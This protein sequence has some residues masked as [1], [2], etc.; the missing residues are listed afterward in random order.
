M[1]LAVVN[2]GSVPA[3]GTQLDA[4]CWILDWI[5]GAGSKYW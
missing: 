5:L 2:V 3:T 4:G 1:S